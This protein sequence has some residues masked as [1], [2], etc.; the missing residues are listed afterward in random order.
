MRQK[1]DR[2]AR[3][4]VVKWGVQADRFYGVGEELPTSQYTNWRSLEGLWIQ[5]IIDVMSAD[6]DKNE[7]DLPG[8][9][10]EDAEHV[11]TEQL[12]ASKRPRR[13]A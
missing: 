2:S 5:G 13:A 9:V 8:E 10:E 11:P 1:F 12:R 3:F 6:E 4:V 7:P